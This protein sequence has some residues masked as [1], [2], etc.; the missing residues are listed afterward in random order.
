MFVLT[1]V[2]K[3]VGLIAALGLMIFGS[4]PCPGVMP[5]DS[6]TPAPTVNNDVPWVC[7]VQTEE[8]QLAPDMQSYRVD[9]RLGTGFLISDGVVLTAAHCINGDFR[10]GIGVR[11]FVMRQHCERV[12]FGEGPN[13]RR[14]YA[15]L[16]INHPRFPFI[17]ADNRPPLTLSADVFNGRRGDHDVG[18]IVLVN[19]PRR[20]DF[21]PPPLAGSDFTPAS[22]SKGVFLGY[23]DAQAEP[24]RA[25]LEGVFELA[26]MD[27]VPWFNSIFMAF[28][29][30]T[31]GCLHVPIPGDSGGPFVFMNGNNQVIGAVASFVEDFGPKNNG[32]FKFVTAAVKGHRSFIDGKDP[33]GRVLTRFTGPAGM[34][35]AWRTASNWSRALGTPATAPRANDV[36]IIDPTVNPD[37][38]AYTIRVNANTAPLDGLLSDATLKIHSATLL[39][40]GFTGALNTGTADMTSNSTSEEPFGRLRVRHM[41]DNLGVLRM[42]TG[43]VQCGSSLIEPNGSELSL[44][45]GPTGLIELKSGRCDA[46]NSAHT[47]KLVNHGKI[48]LEGGYFYG[49]SECDYLDNYNEIELKK[50][51]WVTVYREA[52]NRAS[53]EL[54]A[55]NFNT[56]N[57]LPPFGARL[58][59]LEFKNAGK[60]WLGGR[61]D[62]RLV[63]N[64]AIERRGTFQND[65]S[66]EVW[67]FA[68]AT[69]TGADFLVSKG[70]IKVEGTQHRT[71][72][73]C[74]R[75]AS[76]AF[77]GFLENDGSIEMFENEG[78]V[79]RIA[80][81]DADFEN[82]NLISGKG[83]VVLRGM[84][85]WKNSA[86][87]RQDDYNTRSLRISIYEGLSTDDPA[88]PMTFEA[89]TKLQAVP[90]DGFARGSALE[91]ITIWQG[92]RVKLVN[93]RANESIQ[94]DDVP[95]EA[96]YVDTI[97]VRSG[98]RLDLTNVK[99]YCR[100]KV[101]ENGATIDNP[102]NLI[103]VPAA[104]R[105]C[106]GDSDG[107]GAVDITDVA[108]ALNA[109]GQA[110]EPGVGADVTCDGVISTDDVLLILGTMG[111]TAPPAQIDSED[112]LIAP[113]FP[114][115]HTSTDHAMPIRMPAD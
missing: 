101:I 105:G 11:D 24:T 7:K 111:C 52:T 31:R 12:Q 70:K 97:K 20:S 60:L 88:Q 2:L 10:V 66:G 34:N 19:G 93:E 46:T 39:V 8:T 72:L 18:I 65:E 40:N 28:T 6:N 108:S 92:S 25:P 15:G 27:G 59:A 98:C 104:N 4:Q 113:A 96:V 14:V 61:S 107:S 55:S 115:E 54:S 71:S 51:S 64:P 9:D 53:A 21:N 95:P 47:A 13:Q 42:N 3:S 67:L 50:R 29:T 38:G 37:T 84:S 58:D 62:V 41:L 81:T 45:N 87:T 102:N 35:H 79:A 90:A 78:G 1:R 85:N 69:L 16:G 91:S 110:V 76:N 17:E 73:E 74:T 63:P 30:A 68:G 44:Y 89:T 26:N 22:G 48:K 80:C 56:D 75:S 103:V 36:A 94:G 57:T 100:T 99:L 5:R 23:S 112:V 83:V 33:D 82:K 114:G 86:D 109:I 106:P 77:P 49:S 32:P 43:A